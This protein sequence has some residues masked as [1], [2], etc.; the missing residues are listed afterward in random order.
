MVSAIASIPIPV[1]T[2]AMPSTMTATVAAAVASPRWAGA[3][4][5]WPRPRAPAADAARIGLRL[6]MGDGLYAVDAAG[7]S[8]PLGRTYTRPRM[9][10]Q[11]PP[12]PSTARRARVTEWVTFGFAALLVALVAYFGY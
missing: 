12:E 7:C 2:S 1:I 5:W 11:L 9:P 8:D 10:Y 4:V 3:S 6:V